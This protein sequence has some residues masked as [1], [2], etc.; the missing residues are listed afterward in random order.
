MTKKTSKP[1]NP[2]YIVGLLS[3]CFILSHLDKQILSLLAHPIQQN[4]D[5]NDTQIGLLQGFAFAMC[6]ALA[7][8][9]VARFIDQGNRSRIAALSV[10]L[11]SLATSL[12][13]FAQ[14]FFALAA[15]RAGTASA[16][17]G[18]PP[19][20]FSIFGDILPE[21]QI[22]MAT[23]IFM[24]APY[25]GGG[26][27]FILGGWLLDVYSLPSGLAIATGLEAW[28]LV[29]ISL[30][31][32]GLVL[33]II[34]ARTVKEPVRLEKVAKTGAYREMPGLPV[35]LRF[36]FLE[37]RFLLFYYAGITF[38]TIFLYAFISWYPMHVIRSYGLSAQTVGPA[39]GVSYLVAGLAGTF[40]SFVIMARKPGA[41]V[42]LRIMHIF[43]LSG[44]ILLAF[45]LIVLFQVSYMN[46]VILY[47]VYAFFSATIVCL[48]PVPLQLLVPNRMRGRAIALFSLCTTAVGGSLGPLLVGLLADHYESISIALCLTGSLSMAVTLGLLAMARRALV[49]DET[50]RETPVPIQ[51]QESLS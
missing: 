8:V 30:G 39:I 1:N 34:L 13:G 35:V 20:A 10:A 42:I 18:L 29:F 46:A 16:E 19:A 51:Q 2:W 43:I 22:A 28:Q 45:S 9:P 49:H 48:M 6:Y 24:L 44:S 5:L 3:L 7:G 37:S 14:S 27:A 11:W 4:L 21:R 33:A 36:I 47:A 23:G 50:G 17:A 41:K 40:M 31:I 38:F 26:L 32:P 25:L 12:C 15:A